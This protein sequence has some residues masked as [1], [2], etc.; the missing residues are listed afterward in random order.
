MLALMNF[1]NKLFGLVDIHSKIMKGNIILD[2]AWEDYSAIF[3]TVH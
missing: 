1:P 2:T 3:L